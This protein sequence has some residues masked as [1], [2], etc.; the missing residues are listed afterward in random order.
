MRISL[1][2]DTVED[3]ATHMLQR[4]GY[5][6]W[7]RDYLAKLHWI[8]TEFAVCLARTETGLWYATKSQENYFNCGNNDRWDT[9]D[10]DWLSDSFNRLMVTCLDWTYLKHKTNL[11]HLTPN[12][13]E[14]YCQW[15][16][17]PKCKYVYASSK[18]NRG[19][20]MRNCLS[21]IHNEQIDF[22]YEFRL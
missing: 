2:W 4:Y 14:S 17:D 9:V 11:A 6:Y 16:S 22:T 10:N 20:N 18:E 3:R 7:T 21:N 12:H 15:S 8:K 13:S 5:T 19:N 1:E